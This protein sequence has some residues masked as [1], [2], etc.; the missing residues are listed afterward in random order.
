MRIVA[1]RSVKSAWKGLYWTQRDKKK[2]TFITLL[3]V[4][5]QVDVDNRKTFNARPEE[6]ERQ[7]FPQERNAAGG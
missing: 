7:S 6:G 1:T 2:I 5:E 3:S 4:A